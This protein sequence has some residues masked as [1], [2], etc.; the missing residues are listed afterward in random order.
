M[1]TRRTA[2]TAAIPVLA[3]GVLV[4]TAGTGSASIAATGFPSAAISSPPSVIT[5]R[6][7]GIFPH[8]ID[9]QR[10][11]RS[12]LVGSLKHSTISRVGIDGTVKTLIDDQDLVAV[13]A[14]RDDPRRGRIIATNVDYGLADR[15]T[16]AGTF[17][18][19]G[20]ASYDATTGHR[21][22]YTDLAAVA[23][24]GKQH[25][26]SDVAVGADGTAYAVDELTPTVFRIDA[27]GHA[28]VLVRNDLLAGALNIPNFLDGIGLSAVE[29]LPGNLLILAKGDG[30][31]IRLPIDHPGRISAV[32]LNTSLATITADLRLLPDHSLAVVSS[33]LLT[34]QPAVV[35]RVR[36][37]CRWTAAT[38]T[39]T[40]TVPDP[41]TSGL[42]AGPDGATYALSG[43]LADLLAGKPNEGF[44]LRSVPVS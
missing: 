10:R 31:L 4:S 37:N 17:H 15:S 33:G 38:V 41:V 43:G 42:T 21:Q 23:A 3:F 44:T 40:G 2:I 26:I 30:A 34:G 29:W 36:P 6:G 7:P 1:I 19:A 28:S 22:W 13:Q 32:H 24:D 35:Q 39:V 5:A 27:N 14:V 20:V 16:K 11:T 25:L 12:F 18:V 8:S 9:Y